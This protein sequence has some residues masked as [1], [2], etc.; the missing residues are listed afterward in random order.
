M[1]TAGVRWI[2]ILCS[3]AC[4]EAYGSLKLYSNNVLVYHDTLHQP[5]QYHYFTSFIFF[6]SDPTE[7]LRT[8]Q[9]GAQLPLLA[10]VP[11]ELQP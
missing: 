10:E 6:R 9:A 5:H 4:E 8:Q 2:S 3:R 1:D 11:L 7:G